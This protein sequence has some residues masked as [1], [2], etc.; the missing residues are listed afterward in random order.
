MYIIIII[1]NLYYCILQWLQ[2]TRIGENNNNNNNN[3][4]GDDNVN[5]CSINHN[6]NIHV[7]YYY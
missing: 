3:N 5:N 2:S 6:N 7:T 1:K 4:N